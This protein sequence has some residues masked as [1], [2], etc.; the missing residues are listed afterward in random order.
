MDFITGLPLSGGFNAIYTAVDRLT[1]L[2]RLTPCTTGDD[3]L[4]A[5][6]VAHMFFERV[7]RDFGVPTSVISDRDPRFTGSFWQSL[8][9][10]MGTRLAFSTAFHP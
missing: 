2:V 7:V 8:M 3:S 6:K 10:I 5:G 9:S 1:K 4:A